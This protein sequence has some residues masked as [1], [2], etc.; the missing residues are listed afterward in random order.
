MALPSLRKGFYDRILE[1]KT[2]EG[3]KSEARRLFEVDEDDAFVYGYAA[4]KDQT[5]NYAPVYFMDEIPASEVNLDVKMGLMTFAN[6]ALRTEQNNEA[7]KL[8]Y[9]LKDVYDADRVLDAGSP[10]LIGLRQIGVKQQ[11]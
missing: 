7:L 4:L 9:M 5:R 3:V 8:A 1:N 10:D 6:A 11:V 2:F